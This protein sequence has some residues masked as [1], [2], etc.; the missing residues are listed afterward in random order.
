MAEVEAK[1]TL[2]KKNKK[3]AW[4]GQFFIKYLKTKAL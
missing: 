3:T 4:V 1:N 2:C